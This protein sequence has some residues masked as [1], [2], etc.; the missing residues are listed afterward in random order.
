MNRVE[1]TS[2][3]H[4]QGWPMVRVTMSAVTDSEKPKHNT[5]HNSIKTS[6]SRSNARHFKWRCRCNTSLSAIGILR[7]LRQHCVHP[8]LEGEEEPVDQLIARIRVL[9][10]SACGPRS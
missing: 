5:P 9:I 10:F 7:T 1:V 4:S 8:P 6:S 2:C 3:N